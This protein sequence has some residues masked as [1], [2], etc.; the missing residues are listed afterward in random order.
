MVSAWACSNGI[1]LGQRKTSDKSNEITA[2]PK[3]LEVL[4]IKGCIVTI[5]AMGTQ[6]E[7]AKIINEKEADYVLALKGN[8]GV[9]NE[10]VEDLFSEGL[11]N[12]FKNLNPSKHTDVDKG[13][14]RIE[15]RT[16]TAINV[17]K[18]LENYTKEW[19]ELKSLI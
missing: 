7:I 5:D 10:M 13:H 2:I 6:K 16:C 1:V 3:R 12:N 18:Y 8:Q 11:K 9:L 4:E 14:G 15:E 17:P 19:A